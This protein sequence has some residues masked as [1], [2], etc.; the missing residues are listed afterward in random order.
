MDFLDLVSSLAGVPI[1]LAPSEL[2]MAGIGL[3]QRVSLDAQEIRLDKALEQVLSPL[4]LEVLTEVGSQAV[5]VRRDAAK[6]RE[7][8]YPLDDL[9]SSQTSAE[10]FAKWIQK[11]I[12]PNSWTGAGG[13]GKIAT[14]SNQLRVEQAQSVHYQILFFLERIR[15]AKQLPL[16]SKYPARLLAAKPLDMIVAERMAA[17][18]TFTF[19]HETPLAEVV[20][21]WQSELGLPIFVDW[22]TL[23][24]HNIYP[25]SRVTCGIANQ[26]WH[27]ALDEVLTPLDLG[28]RPAPGG[29]IQITSQAVVHHEAVLDIY[30]AKLWQ[31]KSNNEATVI[32]DPGNNLVYV[33]AP[34]AVQRAILDR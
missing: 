14:A 20:R 27:T 21:Y 10:D 15:L 22:P 34:G 12:E 17:P 3:N 29:A 28:W 8:S 16:R 9:V 2:Q 31:G 26:P 13:S 7:I 11:L 33:R 23:G 6:L 30:P 4:H 19:S 1:S 18:T 25:T 24:E 5:V 32:H